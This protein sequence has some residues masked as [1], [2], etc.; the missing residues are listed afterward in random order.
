MSSFNPS[1][2]PPAESQA[3]VSG[4]EILHRSH[5]GEGDGSSSPTQARGGGKGGSCSCITFIAGP[6]MTR[7]IG[8]LKQWHYLAINSYSRLCADSL[9]KLHRPRGALQGPRAVVTANRVL[10]L[11]PSPHD[12]TTPGPASTVDWLK[13]F[14]P[15][16][17][18]QGPWAKA[19]L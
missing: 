6:R 16:L 14:S 4:A 12:R 3:F 2:H 18:I 11:F 9:T 8:W 7:V 5:R 19:S 1:H 15:P 17:V 10:A 13:H